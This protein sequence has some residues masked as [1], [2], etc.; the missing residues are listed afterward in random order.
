[1]FCFEKSFFQI[2]INF[3]NKIN[4]SF[5]FCNL[6]FNNQIDFFFDTCWFIIFCNSILLNVFNTLSNFRRISKYDRLII[7]NFNRNAKNKI[8]ESKQIFFKRSSNF[9]CFWLFYLFKISNTQ[10]MFSTIEFVTIVIKINHNFENVVNNVTFLFLYL[11]KMWTIIH[12][13]NR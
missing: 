7:K 3:W 2:F 4:F 13:I 11:S 8:R 9:N 5:Q 10:I 1:M 12:L 6:I